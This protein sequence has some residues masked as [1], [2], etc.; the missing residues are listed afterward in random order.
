MKWTH[1]HA[2]AHAH[3]HAHAHSH[4]HAHAYSHSHSHTHTHT[5]T[6]TQSCC[7]TTTRAPPSDQHLSSLEQDQAVLK[8]TFHALRQ[9]HAK[10][11]FTYFFHVTK[12][13]GR[14]CQAQL[15]PPFCCCRLMG[16]HQ[17]PCSLRVFFDNLCTCRPTNTTLETSQS[18]RIN[19]AASLRFEPAY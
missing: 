19:N 8:C 2:H 17:R 14:L 15:L 18:V 10:P 12:T 13:N 3:T 1:T 4:A 9:V 11:P 16:L 7:N 6:H 5:H